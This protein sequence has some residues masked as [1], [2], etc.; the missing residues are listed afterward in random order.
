MLGNDGAT[1][2]ASDDDD[3][4]SDGDMEPKRRYKS[5]KGDAA[6]WLARMEGTRTMAK[7]VAGEHE[8]NKFWKEYNTYNCVGEHGLRD[9]S[10]MADAW[11]EFVAER[12]KSG[13]N[14]TIKYY[15]KHAHMLESFFESGAKSNNIKATLQ[16]HLKS[17]ENLSDIHRAPVASPL[18]A[19]S[20]PGPLATHGPNCTIAV[21]KDHSN[22]VPSIPMHMSNASVLTLQK[23]GPLIYPGQI[24]QFRREKL[25]KRSFDRAPQLC[26]TC[27]HYRHHNTIHNMSHEFTCTVPSHQYNVD[28]TKG[29][30]PCSDCVKGAANVGYQK[31]LEV[32]AHK[33][34]RA[35]KTCTSCGHYKDYGFYKGQHA[36]KTC[37]V[38]K[39]EMR[40]KYQGYCNCENCE[41]TAYSMGRI[42]PSKMRKIYD[43][44]ES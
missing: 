26:T 15:R 16:P 42:K 25:K 18:T 6:A 40:N 21:N 41:D 35:M 19:L 37:N 17:I 28:Q 2:D 29:W 3:E 12:E 38:D 5:E 14:E 8:K 7:K 44:I 9:W 32:T 4:S 36:N 24:Q 10:I 22:M 31:P 20:A 30:C 39:G 34:K 33:S 11:N 13:Q 23:D 43:E 1:A 27:R